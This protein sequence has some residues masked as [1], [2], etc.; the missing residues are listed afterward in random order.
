MFLLA[1]GVAAGLVD[2]GAARTDSPAFAVGL[3]VLH[4]VDHTR[5]IRLP[6]G[7]REARPL[8][9]YVR[10]PALGAATGKDLLDAPAARSAGPFPLVV[11]GHGYRVTPATYARLLRAW[12]QAGYVV[13]APV[14]PLSNQHAPGGPNEA[15][16]INQPTDL[17]FVVSQLIAA[18]NTDD[19]PLSG[20]IDPDEIAVAGHS[21]GADTALAAAYNRHVRDTRFGAAM[22]FSGAEMSGLKG[23]AYSPG[24]PA[25]LAVQGTA[26]PYN[27][28]KFTREFFDKASHPK[29]LLTLLRAGHL[30]PFTYQQPQ[31]GIVER[32]TIA[33]LDRYLEHG[34][35]QE[36][37]AAG[38][39]P[40]IA[41]L[42]AHP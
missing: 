36:L 19:D 14:F 38:R 26:D 41:Q 2:R 12:T 15:D 17:R 8:V 6:G 33:F 16:L 42:T 39:A 20:M 21:D 7:R 5:T 35:L 32:V 40:G 37:I 25:L 3:R 9:T 1:A 10:Y 29:F 27:P 34:S 22:I 24:S 13:A 4:F 31:L 30:P 11:F 23:Y 28:P 18:G